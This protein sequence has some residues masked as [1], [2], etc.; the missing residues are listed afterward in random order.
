MLDS[1][2]EWKIIFKKNTK[3]KQNQNKETKRNEQTNKQKKQ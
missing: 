1:Y 2:L 3:T